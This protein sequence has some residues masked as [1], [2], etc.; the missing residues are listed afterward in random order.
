MNAQ[1]T[2]LSITVPEISLREEDK[3]EW[4]SAYEKAP[5]AR[6]AKAPFAAKNAPSLPSVKPSYY[7]LP[8]QDAIKLIE[9]LPHE[10]TEA[11]RPIAVYTVL[12]TDI[13]AQLCIHR[14]WGWSCALNV[15]IETSGEV[16]TFYDFD[17]GKKEVT[18]IE[19]FCA[20]TKEVWVMNSKVP[21]GVVFP[22]AA[23]RKLINFSF[24][25]LSYRQVL[26]YL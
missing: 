14:D 8:P 4:R 22:V 18:P 13:P 3:F 9:Q 21:H 25:R 19:S 12:T 2:N 23:T 24:R 16:T 20:A 6:L 1:Q 7:V 15:Y 5:A 17:T 26:D 11:E 10:L